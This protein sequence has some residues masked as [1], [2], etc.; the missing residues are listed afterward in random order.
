MDDD[1]ARVPTLLLCYG[2]LDA[3]DTAISRLVETAAEGHRIAVLRAGAPT[4]P[5]T[6]TEMEPHIVI[7]STPVGCVCCTAGSMFRAALFG[8]LRSSCPKRLVVDLGSGDHV[9]KL[10]AE[11]HR[12]SLCRVLRLVGRIDL[13]A[14]L[15]IRNLDWPVNLPSP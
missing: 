7:R 9:P 3:R 8:L 11:M 1:D 5:N 2:R 4:L 14:L 12:E 13:T 15:D 6:A 10:E